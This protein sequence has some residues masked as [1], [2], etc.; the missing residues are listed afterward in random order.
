MEIL[1]IDKAPDYI[2]NV[3]VLLIQTTFYFI[4]LS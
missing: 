2:F 4:N 3:K 1:N